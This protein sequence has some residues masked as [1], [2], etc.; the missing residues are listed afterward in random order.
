MA[1]T[2]HRCPK[3]KRNPLFWETT[4]RWGPRLFCICGY[5]RELGG[6]SKQDAQTMQLRALLR[7]IDRNIERLPK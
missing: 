4:R 5:S 1:R 3:C 2:K 6:V 7:S